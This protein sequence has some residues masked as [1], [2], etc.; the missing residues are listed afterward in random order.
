MNNVNTIRNLIEDYLLSKAL[1]DSI[2]EEFLEVD[3]RIKNNDYMVGKT[4]TDYVFP[5]SYEKRKKKAVIGLISRDLEIIEDCKNEQKIIKELMD[6]DYRKI[7][8]LVVKLSKEEYDELCRILESIIKSFDNVITDNP[9]SDGNRFIPTI[10]LTE[11]EKYLIDK[12]AN[13]I[14]IFNHIKIIYNE[15]ENVVVKVR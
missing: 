11:Y 4:V 8:E 2:N 15:L 1:Y 14:D 5:R 9:Y 7:S 13:Y 6:D 3:K 12:K 10:G